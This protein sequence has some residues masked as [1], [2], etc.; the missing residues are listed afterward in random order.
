M[1]SVSVLLPFKT[2]FQT[3][4]KLFFRLPKV[5]KTCS[6]IETKIQEVFKIE[7]S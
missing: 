6:K 7:G 3:F 1:P 4:P 5:F 2:F